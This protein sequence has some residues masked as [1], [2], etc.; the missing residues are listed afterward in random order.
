MRLSKELEAMTNS[1]RELPTFAH[2]GKVWTVD[3]RLKEFRFVVFGEMPEFVPFDSE[4]GGL[5]LTALL[6][7]TN[8]C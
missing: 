1:P 4:E 8:K 5:L 7:S 2:L 6:G 3:L